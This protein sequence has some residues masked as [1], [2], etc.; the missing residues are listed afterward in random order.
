MRTLLA[1]VRVIDFSWIG[2]GSYTT[3]MLADLGADVVKIESSQRLDTLRVTKPFKDGKA[4]VNRSG[5]FAD[6]NSSKRSM[7]L[8]VKD[9]RGLVLAKRLIAGG[10]L[11]T[12][13][14][15]P[16]VMDKLG[17]GYE[18]ARKVS[19]R[20]VYASMSMQ[21]AAGP[22][23]ND[24]GYGLTI[25]ALTGLQHMTGLPDRQP[26]GTGT[27]FPDHIPNP[28]HAAF[29]ILAALRHQRR[30]GEG[31]FIDLAQM[32]PTLAMM[33]PSLMNYMVNG[34][35]DGRHG[36]ARPSHAPSGV[37]PCAGADRWIAIEVC[38]DTQWAA[39]ARALDLPMPAE[40]A[41]TDGRLRHRAAIDA[42]VAART[43]SRDMNELVQALQEAGTPAGAVYD[44]RDVMRD[45]QLAERGHWVTLNHPEMGP[46]TYNAPPYRFSDAH[47]EP[48]SPA[49]LLGQHTIEVC[50]D[51]LSLDDATVRQL[52]A[53]GVLS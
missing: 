8:N 1:G 13:N 43:P 52:N 34:V 20:I 36:N 30:T 50:R 51:L 25:A 45:P 12:N 37:Y 18:A 17:L 21:G 2:A 3:K 47:S 23:K 44:A 31:Q 41:T 38:N 39:L 5:Y 16:G 10:H 11:V 14:F 42:E 27:N 22:E 32:E 29:A 15:T 26:A 9:P 40:W 7:T 28:G 4:G 49:P 33:G 46:S 53:D 35:I 24:L 19:P 48:T 6:R